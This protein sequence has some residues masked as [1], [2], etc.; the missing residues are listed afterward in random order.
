MRYSQPLLRMPSSCDGCGAQFSL[1]H[2]LDCKKGRL[3]TQRH[4]E[5]RD[6]LWDIAALTNKE[7]V[8]EPVVREA[9]E[10]SEMPALIADL[11]VRGFWQPQSEALF[12]IRVIDTDAQSYACQSVSAILSA[13]E[14]EEKEVFSCSSSTACILY[15]FCS[16]SRRS[17]GTGGTAYNAAFCR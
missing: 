14:R 2:A 8:R 1:G 12:D 10:T 7:V 4:N 13:A 3:I 11:G 9:D 16:V 6:A 15:P 5:V 17:H